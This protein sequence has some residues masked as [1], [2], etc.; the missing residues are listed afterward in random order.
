MT[1]IEVVVAL[2]VVLIV[3]LGLLAW[4]P[5]ARERGR[6]TG[7][8]R[9]LQRIGSGLALYDT[10]T[11]RLPGVARDLAGTAPLPAILGQLGL[12]EFAGLDAT[13][14]A[15]GAPTAPPGPRVLADV[16]CPA[17]AAATT[18][19]FVAPVSY[20]ANAGEAVGGGDGPFAP[21][22][23]IALAEVRDADGTEYTVGFAERL[24]GTGAARAAA[25]NYAVTAGSVADGC[26]DLRDWR[27]DAGSD[28][29]KVGWVSTLYNHALPPG[30]SPSCVAAD[31][32][33]ARMGASSAHGGLVHVLWLDGRATA[34]RTTIDPAVWR[35]FGTVGGSGTAPRDE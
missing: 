32:R 17:D 16:V 12:T 15:S 2:G 1:L 7:C 8:L 31:G 28:W 19:G 5:A 33:S 14:R 34:V 6:R 24:V 13:S 3:L 35:G 4:L 21:G 26:V 9:N 18:R 30:G 23:T 10:A 22:R 11:G 20:R 27:G 29:S 25:E